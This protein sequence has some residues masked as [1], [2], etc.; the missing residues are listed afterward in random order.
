MKMQRDKVVLVDVY[1]HSIGELE[2]LEAHRQ[3][4][5][6]RAF[7]VFVLNDRRELL[8]QQRADHK[9]HG[10]GLWTNTCCSHPQW[11]ENVG[12]AARRRLLYEMG[13]E[14]DLKFSHSFIY[15][16]EVEND[17]VEHEFDHVFV[18]Y[19]NTDPVINPLEVKDY[20]WAPLEQIISDFVE[21]PELY[22]Y[23]FKMALPG[24]I[25]RGI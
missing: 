24:V 19:S 25:S 21:F 12:E 6:H 13:M 14:C 18:G 23:W 10:G 22:T 8:L 15:R 3:G 17:L 16:A 7:S 2:K 11:A 4:M 1:D 9:Y 20:K 5:L